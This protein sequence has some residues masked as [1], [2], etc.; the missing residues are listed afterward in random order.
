M[1]GVITP[2]WQGMQQTR[3]KLNLPPKNREHRRGN[4]DA[5][6]AGFT[7]GPGAPVSLKEVI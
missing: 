4:F 2:L 5:I 6:S 7:M 1:E 3:E